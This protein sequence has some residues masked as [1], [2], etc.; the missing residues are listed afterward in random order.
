[1]E[2]QS[3]YILKLS[4]NTILFFS[5][6]N[7][8]EILCKI[9]NDE[10]KSK[11]FH[12]IENCRKNFSVVLLP[13]DKVYILYQNDSGDMMINILEDSQWNCVKLLENKNQKSFE[14]YYK[15]IYFNN[16]LNIFYSI[17]NKNNISINLL[18]QEVNLEFNTFAPI[19]LDSLSSNKFKIHFT[20]SEL[21]IAYEKL[22]NQNYIIGYKSFD[23]TKKSWSDFNI[24][25]QNSSPYRDFSLLSLDN[26]IH[27]LYIK[28][29]KDRNNLIHSHGNKNSYKYNKIY[30][31][32][33]IEYCILNQL[34]RKLSLS[35]IINNTKFETY[36]IDSGNTFYNPPKF[37]NILSNRL[38]KTNYQVNVQEEKCSTIMN[39]LYFSS[40][41]E[42]D[43]FINLI[44]N[45]TNMHS[46]KIQSEIN[47]Q[48]LNMINNI[49]YYK[50]QLYSKDQLI[51][52]LKYTLKE[53]KKKYQSLNTRFS[54]LK[55]ELESLKIAKESYSENFNK[56]QDLLLLKN[57]KIT[58]LE[59]ELLANEE[60]IISLNDE[61]SNLEIQLSELKIELSTA[62][63]SIFR[64]LFPK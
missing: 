31:H 48:A 16:K 2:I 26:Q 25:D 9:T 35:W 33:D 47:N 14:V 51:I 30:S 58:E 15:G 39:E 50:R 63:S 20:E 37:N 52:Q 12:V 24:L 44:N 23:K 41:M 40:D 61:I 17:T 28:T 32:K 62:N 4:N 8:N 29:K 59:K 57:D 36:S 46:K 13:D 56:L 60:K 42:I 27:A 22:Y 49:H 54:K 5:Y 11:L 21:F 38:I 10:D 55:K 1:M 18:H 7:N 3:N 19:Q 64:K 6:N 45:N 53:D 34:N 43:S